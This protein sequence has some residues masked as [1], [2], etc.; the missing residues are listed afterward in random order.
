MLHTH[1]EILPKI[2][3][4]LLAESVPNL[5]FNM[6]VIYMKLSNKIFDVLKWI[7]II[8]L[9]STATFITTVFPIWNLPDGDKIAQTITAVATLLGAYLMISSVN[10]KNKKGE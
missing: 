8:G 2:I 6:E 5:D 10:Y 3:G 4:A 7:A 1:S 9:P